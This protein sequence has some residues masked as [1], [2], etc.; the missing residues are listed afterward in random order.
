MLMWSS[1]CR[2]QT[3]NHSTQGQKWQPGFAK[4]SSI[5]S[6]KEL[7]HGRQEQKQTVKPDVFRLQD[8]EAGSESW[9]L[10]PLLSRHL[11]ALDRGSTWRCL[12]KQRKVIC[13]SRTPHYK[14]WRTT[15][16]CKHS[17]MTGITPTLCLS[18]KC[19]CVPRLTDVSSEL[20]IEL[21][22]YEEPPPSLSPS[23]HDDKECDEEDEE[24]PS[25]LQAAKSEKVYN[26]SKFRK[27]KTFCLVC[28]PCWSYIDCF[29]SQS[30]PQ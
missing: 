4:G 25:F 19:L 5:N 2:D 14:P 8:G 29:V 7:Q 30:P 28:W 15:S 24:L 21:S 3:L 10:R 13:L 26:H 16:R 17:S 11:A 20:S 23:I 18:A 6:Q 27:K 22:H 12:R 1:L 9:T